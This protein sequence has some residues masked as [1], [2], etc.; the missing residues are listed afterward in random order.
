LSLHSGWL[1]S[2]CQRSMAGNMEL[3]D[4]TLLQETHMASWAIS[5]PVL[6]NPREKYESLY[7]RFVLLSAVLELPI[8]DDDIN[9]WVSLTTSVTSVLTVVVRECLCKLHLFSHWPHD[10][11]QSNITIT[12]RY[13]TD[14]S[15]YSYNGTRGGAFGWGTALEACWHI[16]SCPNWHF[17]TT[18][19]EA[20]PCFFLS[21]K[22]ND[23]VP[24]K[25][26][27]W[28]ALYRSKAAY[29]FRD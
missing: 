23:R 1:V 6:V 15:A 13:F 28:P 17:T 3:S 14:T 18:L 25:N 4:C 10:K 26:E 11:K 19:T 29:F 16:E 22:A 27:A 5:S 12:A 8:L 7:F 20:F 24:R 2:R 9:G 21:C